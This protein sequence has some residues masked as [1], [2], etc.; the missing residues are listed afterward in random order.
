[1]K[2]FT[3]TAAAL[4]AL[5]LPALAQECPEGQRLF[6]H[7]AGADCIPEDPQ[8][9][10][11]LQDQNGLLP[12]MEL[13]VRPVGS[14]G[15]I[16][17][18]GE[19]IFRRMEGYDT[20]GIEWIGTYGTAVDPE[21]IAGLDPDLIVASPWPPEAPELYGDIA[22][23]VVIDMFEQP[24]PDALFQFADLVNRTDR[25]EELQAELEARMDEVREDLGPAL[26]ATT[27]SFLTSNIEDGQFY[28]TNPTQ[29]MGVILRGLDPIRPAAESDLA[30]N[31][32]YR[33]IETIGAHEADVMF[34]LVFD[35]DDRG[36]SDAYNAFTSHPLVQATEVAQAGQIFPLDGSQMVGSAWRKV[37]NGLDQIAAV[38]TRENLNRDLVSE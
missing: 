4:A 14:A 10:V 28:P 11:T 15:H 24:L 27:V 17:N 26:E 13:G 6:D 25:A 3:I 21:V 22:P 34:Q 8:R 2:T 37:M 16:T 18:D 12:L 33:S 32:E 7:H 35:A 30:D 29:A 9:I 23:V 20:A 1:M 5:A 36:D 19:R 31:R 38:L